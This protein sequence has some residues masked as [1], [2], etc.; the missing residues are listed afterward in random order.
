MERTP[1]FTCC[2][3][4]RLVTTLAV[5]WFGW[6]DVPRAQAAGAVLVGAGDISECHSSGDSATAKLVQSIGGTVFTLGDNAYR[7]GTA[8]Q[9]QSCYGPTWGRF[10]AAP[11]RQPATTSTRRRGRRRTGTTSA[12]AAG[13]R[14]KGWYSYNAG[15][16]HV[17]VLNSNC[18]HGRLRQGLGAGTLAAQP[19]WPATTTS[20]PWPTCTM[21]G[22]P[23]TGRTA[24][25]E[26][27]AFWEAL[28]DYGA[29]LVLIGH[30]HIYERFAPA[31]AVGDG[32]RRSGLRQIIVGTGGA[33]PLRSPV[34]GPT[35]RS[36]T[37]APT[38]CS[39]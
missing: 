33:E 32:R 18:G 13:P 2:R 12:A 36:A 16:W 11:G 14:G 25:A 9:F 37:P 39:S 21:P 15:A 10:K 38:G 31:D 30:S 35:A 20:A 19:T 26:V 6:V 4:A 22:S 5:L 7:D 17:I 34:P 29:D 8:K 27:R 23:P 3:T 24:L 1:R 28:Y